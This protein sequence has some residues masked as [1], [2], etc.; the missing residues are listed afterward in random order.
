MSSDC[1]GCTIDAD[2]LYWLRVLRVCENGIDR[3]VCMDGACTV[4]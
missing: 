1:V 4:F 3:A 2:M